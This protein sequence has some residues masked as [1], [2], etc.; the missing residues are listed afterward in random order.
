MRRSTILRLYPN[1]NTAYTKNSI[2]EQQNAL[3]SELKKEI[4]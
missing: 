3:P 4:I 2:I 1:Y